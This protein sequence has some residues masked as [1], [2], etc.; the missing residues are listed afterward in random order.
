MGKRET[1]GNRGGERERERE[2][3]FLL[4]A[5][6]KRMEI[7]KLSAINNF[8][9]YFVCL[10]NKRDNLESRAGSCIITLS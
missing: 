4:N 8:L 6:Y 2:N 10:M 1:R 9:K 7:K 3:I 5:F